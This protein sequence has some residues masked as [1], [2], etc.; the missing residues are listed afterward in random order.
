MDLVLCLA[1]KPGESVTER[2][3]LEGLVLEETDDR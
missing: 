2:G 1:A 3:R